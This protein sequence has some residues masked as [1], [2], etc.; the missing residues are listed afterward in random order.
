ME[1]DIERAK[2]LI[3]RREEIDAELTALFT[4]EKKK[5]SPVKCSNCDKEG[6][7]ARNCPDKMPAVGI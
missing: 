2:D 5:R 1:I 6:H 4:G 7:T 3:A